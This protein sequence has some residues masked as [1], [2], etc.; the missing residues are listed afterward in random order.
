VTTDL[1]VRD[2]SAPLALR[3]GQMIFDDLQQKA[4]A[5]MGVKNATKADLAVFAHVCHRTM[6]DPFTRQIYMIERREKVNDKWVSKQTIQT[7]IDGF[8]VVRDRAAERTGCEAELEDTIWYD[9]EGRPHTEWLWDAPPVACKVV[10]IK[11]SA[12]GRAL[13]FPAVLR[14]AAYMA[15]KNGQPVSQWKTQPD[16]MIEKCCEAFATRR[17][18]PNDFSGV[19]LEEE[20]Q[21]PRGSDEAAFRKISAAEIMTPGIP[22]DDDEAADAEIVPDDATDPVA[23]SEPAPRE[24]TA[25]EVNDHFKALGYGVKDKDEVLH[26]AST[27]AGRKLATAVADLTPA[28]LAAVAERLESCAGKGDVVALLAEAGGAQPEGGADGE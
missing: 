2:A 6:L 16:H 28:Q 26:I 13:R 9:A 21:G 11:H 24:V 4:L 12:A 25:Q 22:A 10:L 8:R 7:G 20:M 19:Y 15:M 3:P 27:L 17:A 1:A 18:F 23:E 5:A 14:T